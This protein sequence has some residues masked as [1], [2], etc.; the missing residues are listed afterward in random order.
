MTRQ[1]LITA[2]VA[3]TVSGITAHF[4]ACTRVNA[5]PAAD[6]LRAQRL[7][8][9]DSTGNARIVMD[10][11]PHGIAKISFHGS[12]TELNSE[13]S[14]TI[15]GEM[16]MR[17]AGRAQQPS[18]FLGSGLNVGGPRIVMNGNSR[19]GQKILLGFLTDDV[20]TKVSDTW[21][22]FLPVAAGSGYYAGL[23]VGRIPGKLEPHGFIL[24]T[25]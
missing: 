24:P 16:T 9:V 14:Q 22:L 23:G 25:K 12:D 3:F 11:D 2:L 5:A 20:P 15:T 21:G 13:I 17:F 7:E 4:V 18:I 8:I 19:S 6:T 10:I 1:I